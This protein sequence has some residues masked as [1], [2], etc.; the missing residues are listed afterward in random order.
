MLN[1]RP[2]M[3][4]VSHRRILLQIYLKTTDLSDVHASNISIVT[5]LYTDLGTGQ[6]QIERLFAFVSILAGHQRNLLWGEK[7]NNWLPVNVSVQGLTPAN[8]FEVPKS[9]IFN[10]PL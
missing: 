8:R 2:A 6:L 9:E 3:R 10:T 7:G 4:A 1:Y 5:L